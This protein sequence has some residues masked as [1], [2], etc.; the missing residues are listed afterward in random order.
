MINLIIK[1]AMSQEWY[2]VSDT[3][4]IAKGKNQYIQNWKQVKRLYKRGFKSWQK[5]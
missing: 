2:G 1:L 3:V 5:K 4:E